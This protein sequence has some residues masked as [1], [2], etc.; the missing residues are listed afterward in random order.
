M[1]VDQGFPLVRELPD[2]EERVLRDRVD[3]VGPEGRP[4]AMRLQVLDLAVRL[5]RRA[6]LLRGSVR[7]VE[8]HDAL[9][10][11]G[12][13]PHVLDRLRGSVHVE[14]HVVEG[15][16]PGLDHLEACEFRP[17]VD[18]LRRELRLRRP[19]PRLQPGR[20]VE[21]VRVA[22]EQRHRGMR[23]QVH[24]P[25]ERDLSPAVE[26]RV[27][28]AALPDLRDAVPLDVEVG[29]PAV[30]VHV[31]DQG[32]HRRSPSALATTVR[33][34]A[35]FSR[36][37][38]RIASNVRGSSTMPWAK[39]S[40]VQSEAYGIPSSHARVASE[41]IVI[42]TTSPTFLKNA[43]SAR[44][45]RR[46]PVV[47]TYA[48]PSLTEAP[49]SFAAPT[50]ARR[51][52]ASREGVE[53]TTRSSKKVGMF[54][55]ATKSS[56]TTK[57]PGWI[58]FWRDPVDDV[59]MMWLAPTSF[60]A[61]RFARWFSLCGGIRWSLPCRGRKAT[62]TP[63]WRPTRG[64]SLGAPCGVT[65]NFACSS[66]SSKA[67]PRAEPPMIPISVGAIASDENPS[68]NKDS[69]PVSQ[70]GPSQGRGRGPGGAVVARKVRFPSG[71]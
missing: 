2:P 52:V 41:A 61:Q 44:V 60:S 64:G 59:P 20:Q 67:S 66:S 9:R 62:G 8:V 48:P 58:V 50:R 13:E 38:L 49:D 34:R 43:I 1:D 23:V 47:C 39:L 31:P 29:G 19:D 40:T 53:W 12:P 18:V 42:P 5:L 35:A 26:D 7:I 10:E 68:F 45:S 25:R 65:R 28:L 71:P 56:G 70:R 57:V 24:E 16:R 32:A 15:R 30:D 14:I 54:Q 37:V 22:A 6:E 11:E 36:C 51:K 3:R 33:V 27:R 55:K 69:I 63:A 17:P 4:D 46:G 21:V